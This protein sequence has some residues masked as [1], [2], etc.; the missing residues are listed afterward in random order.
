ME[1]ELL[2][3]PV[4]A[5]E[6]G[7]IPELVLSGVTGE[8]F[9]A[10]NTEELAAKVQKL[11]ENA[12]RLAALRDGCRRLAAGK[13]SLKF[14]NTEQYCRKLLLIYQGKEQEAVGK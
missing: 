4:L 14:D 1:S 11:W 2:G 3:T 8:L 10:G 6:L 9:E 12:D 5:S 13:L 7:G